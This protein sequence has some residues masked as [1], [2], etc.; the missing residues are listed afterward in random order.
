[1]LT[2]S[3]VVKATNFRLYSACIS[4]VMSL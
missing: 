1:V 2:I 4:S 3:I